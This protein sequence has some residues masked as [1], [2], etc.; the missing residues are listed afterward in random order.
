M[1]AIA[2]TLQPCLLP[3][4][5]EST[6]WSPAYHA[7]LKDSLELPLGLCRPGPWRSLS[8]WPGRGRETSHWQ[9]GQDGGQHLAALCSGSSLDVI[10]TWHSCC[11]SV[12]CSSDPS[13]PICKTLW[14]DCSLSPPACRW[15][16]NSS[17]QQWGP[18]GTACLDR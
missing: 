3:V 4:L 11:F 6:V 17:L 15:R 8:A 16:L 9:L 1:H 2:A 12:E 7:L 10:F 14:F 13:F 18:R 5:D